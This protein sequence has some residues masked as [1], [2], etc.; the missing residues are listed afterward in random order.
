MMKKYCLYFIIITVFSG[1]NLYPQVKSGNEFWKWTSWTLL[2]GLP[3]VSFFEDRD[4]N[5]SHL[6]FGLEWQVTPVSYSFNANKYV[7]KFNFFFI[8]PVKRFSG[9]V[10]LFFEPELVPGGFK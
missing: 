10:E 9:S 7:S 8:N 1:G 3:T 4:E 2:Q 5:N 6:K